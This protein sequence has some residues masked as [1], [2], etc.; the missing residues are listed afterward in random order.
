MESP[1][2]Q[3]L[4]TC[5]SSHVSRVCSRP[6]GTLTH[7]LGGFVFSPLSSPLSLIR[8]PEPGLELEDFLAHTRQLE[9]VQAPELALNPGPPL[10]LEL[11][12]AK[13]GSQ[14]YHMTQSQLWS[15]NKFR[16]QLM[17]KPPNSG[18]EAAL[19][20][21]PGPDSTPAGGASVCPDNDSRGGPSA[22]STT[23]LSASRSERQDWRCSQRHRN[24]PQART[25]VRA[26]D[27]PAPAPL[28]H[29]GQLPHPGH[30]RGGSAP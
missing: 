20:S 25:G 15:E 13:N 16:H 14:L 17:G 5:C 26:R 29:Q 9:V 10:G 23:R 3:S 4:P 8:A 11:V 7:L 19:S 18:T 30:T 2:K 27:S 1:V 28:Q 24:Q 12:P 21:V 6:L 22:G